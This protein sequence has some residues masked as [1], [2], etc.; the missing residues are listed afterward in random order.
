MEKKCSKCGNEQVRVI[1]DKFYDVLR[2]VC[3]TCRNEW[4]SKTLDKEK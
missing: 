4:I 3:E 2:V 1:Y